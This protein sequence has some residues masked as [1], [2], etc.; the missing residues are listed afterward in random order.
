MKPLLKWTGGKSSE[1][2]IIKKHLPKKFDNFVEPFIGGGAVYFSIE[3]K[4]NIVNDFNKELISFYN[5]LKQT[6]FNQFEKII[7]KII[8]ERKR[9]N[10]LKVDNSFNDNCKKIKN[11]KTYHKYLTR[12][13]N[14]KAKIIKKIN[15]ELIK[16]KKSGIN[17]EESEEHKRTA[18]QAALYYTYRELYNQQNKKMAYD[19]KHLAYWFI[20]RELGYGGMFRFSKEGN[21][22]V[23]YGGLS[24]NKKDL[25]VKLKEIKNLNKKS[26]YLNT[27]FNNLDFEKFFEKYDYFT[28]N[29]FIFLDP[30]YD[31]EFSQ[32]NKE[33]DFTRNDQIR[34]KNSLLKTKAKILLIIKN[35]EFIHNLYKDDFKI[36]NFNKNY[37]VNFKNRNN[38]EVN[39]LIITNY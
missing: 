11:N 12:E 24:Y 34:L 28:K 2:P 20:M 29:D 14:S 4:Q 27:E 6:N 9:I 16:N 13:V 7:K 31:S 35:T 21:F 37:S 10:N 3:H 26:F 39:H 15:E 38:Q 32:Y 8:N 23:P 36:K 30:P 17:K 25:E 22:N 5:L 1:L 33:E 19:Q 18:A